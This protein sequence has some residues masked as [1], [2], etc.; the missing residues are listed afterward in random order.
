[1]ILTWLALQSIPDDPMDR[2]FGG[3]K[4]GEDGR[5]NDDDLVDCISSAIED[6]AGSFG[7]R[8]VPQV[9]RP[10]EVMGILHGRK[11]NVAG[12]KSSILK[13][14]TSWVKHRLLNVVT[15]AKP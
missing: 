14:C 6:P 4:K 8:N 15:S 3:Y 13:H 10:V 2:T 11:W 5:F 9:L 12:R 7:A 1:M